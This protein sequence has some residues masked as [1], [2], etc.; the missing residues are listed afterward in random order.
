MLKLKLLKQSVHALTM[1]KTNHKEMVLLQR[2]NS[3]NR[4]SMSE[5]A[6]TVKVK[7]VYFVYTI[8]IMLNLKTNILY[9]NP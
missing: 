3:I 2:L 8:E 5:L 4:I 1:G 7:K 6:C 9:F